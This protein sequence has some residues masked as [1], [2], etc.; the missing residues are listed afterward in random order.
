MSI[1]RN[2]DDILNAADDSVSLINGVNAGSWDVSGME[3]SE[4]NDMV[5]RNVDHL[6]IVLA[7]EEVVADD[8][9]KS[10]YTDAVSVGDAYIAAN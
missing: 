2:V 9:D 3:Q 8:R 5:Q 4:I 6:N 7:Y 1:E 10:S